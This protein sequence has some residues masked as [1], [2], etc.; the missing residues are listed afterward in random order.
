MKRLRLSSLVAGIEMAAD[1]EKFA[2]DDEDDDD[3]E[4]VERILLTR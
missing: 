2:E 3:E 1:A 4:V